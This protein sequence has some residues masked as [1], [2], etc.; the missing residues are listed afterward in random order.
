MNKKMLRM[1]IAWLL[2]IGSVILMMLL[3]GCTKEGR[4]NRL[5]VQLKGNAFHFDELIGN[6]TRTTILP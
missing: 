1:I 6:N 5:S 2:A 3:T 4:D